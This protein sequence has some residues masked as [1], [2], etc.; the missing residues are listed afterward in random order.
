MLYIRNLSDFNWQ[1]VTVDLVKSDNAYRH[2]FDR[3][4]PE[5]GHPAEAFTDST[6]F[7]FDDS[8]GSTRLN[9]I[10]DRV[11]WRASLGN[12]ANLDSASIAIATPFAAQWTGEVHTCQ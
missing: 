8:P 1:G 10:G 3:M 2:A 12:F 11:A 7:S 6:Q 5:T 4:P 9:P